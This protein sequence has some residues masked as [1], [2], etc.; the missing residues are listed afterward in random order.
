MYTSFEFETII[1]VP[2]D[3]WLYFRLCR[4][5]IK[6]FYSGT[7]PRAGIQKRGRLTTMDKGQE[8]GITTLL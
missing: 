1:I 3:F 5:I 7:N 6:K 4:E 8:N 2:L